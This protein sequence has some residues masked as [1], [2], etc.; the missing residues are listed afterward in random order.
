MLIGFLRQINTDSKTT[1]VGDLMQIKQHEILLG[2]VSV[3]TIRLPV[4]LLLI[5]SGAAPGLLVV[6]VQVSTDL[7][8][9]VA[10]M[11]PWSSN[12]LLKVSSD[13]GILA[14]VLESV[15]SFV[16]LTLCVCVCVFVSIVSP[17]MLYR[18]LVSRG[19]GLSLSW[20]YL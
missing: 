6:C 17:L 12:F 4:S 16:T 13:L 10:K 18:W 2:V 11:K 7:L 3:C 5:V 8:L 14:L 20:P 1:P 19:G 15:E 9:Q